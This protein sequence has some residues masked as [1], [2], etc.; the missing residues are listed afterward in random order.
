[1]HRC[2]NCLFRNTNS[3]LKL[4]DSHL[5]TLVHTHNNC[6]HFEQFRNC[7]LKHTQ[8]LQI[9]NTG[10][11]TKS[12]EHRPKIWNEWERIFAD[13]N[14]APPSTDTTPTCFFLCMHIKKV[15]T[16]PHTTS[17]LACAMQTH[18]SS[19]VTSS[20]KTYALINLGCL[21]S[22]CHLVIVSDLAYSEGAHARI[23]VCSKGLVHRDDSENGVKKKKNS[24]VF[25]C[26]CE[27]Q[28]ALYTLYT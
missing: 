22:L 16:S 17:R 8:M 20:V 6:K 24:H 9:W 1:M 2:W 12:S 23:Y 19:N 28:F 11:H 18:T 7:I 13:I 14:H 25:I 5:V 27:L 26:E 21:A 4:A 3:W 15:H 10:S